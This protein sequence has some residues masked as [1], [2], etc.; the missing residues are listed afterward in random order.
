MRIQAKQCLVD[1]H[2]T[3]TYSPAQITL[4]K[5]LVKWARSMMPEAMARREVAAL[6]KSNTMADL[7]WAIRQSNCTTVKSLKE[8]L[9]H[10]RDKRDE[11]KSSKCIH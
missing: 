5:K 9:K 11:V 4:A 6:L 8:T 7:Q 1:F 2:M 10:K 3:F